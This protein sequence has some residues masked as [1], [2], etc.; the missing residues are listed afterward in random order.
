MHT[1]TNSLIPTPD[2][3]CDVWQYLCCENRPIVIYGMGN[4]ADKLILRFEKLGIS[5][6][7]IFASDE[8]VRGQTFHGKRVMRFSEI[9]DKYGDGN[10]VIVVAFASRFRNMIDKISDMSE[11][12]DVYIPDMPVVGEEYFDVSFYRKNYDALLSVLDMLSDERSKKVFAGIVKYKL[13]G[14]YGYLSDI[15]DDREQISRLIGTSDIDSYIDLGAYNGD[16]VKEYLDIA[17]NPKCVIAVEADKKT[18]KRLLKYADEEKRT[19]VRCINAAVWDTDG[20]LGFSSS[21]NRN[22]SASN[23]S[24]EHTDISVNSITLDGI[25]KDINDDADIFI[26]YDV[27]GA[28]YKAV[29]GSLDTIKRLRPTL[30][31]SVYH[32]SEDL[33]SIPILL[34]NICQNYDFYLRKYNC[35]PAWEINLIAK[36]R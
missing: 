30:S 32:R 29:M 26:K 8:F 11:K 33:F 3:V 27:E 36:P 23:A 19:K 7:D 4:G 10:F 16:T 2:S 5:Y 28:E 18:Y 17:K 1:D 12:Y 6:S 35:F 31:V 22:S 25:A 14:R 20:V 15:C 13:S 34:K 21:G 24:Y 9:C